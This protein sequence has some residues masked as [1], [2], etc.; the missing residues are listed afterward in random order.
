MRAGEK[1]AGRRRGAR[2]WVRIREGPREVGWKSLKLHVVLKKEI[3]ISEADGVSSSQRH[4]TQESPVEQEESCLGI[5]AMLS[6]CWRQPWE[7]C[8]GEQDGVFQE[9]YAPTT[10]IREVLSRG[11]YSCRGRP[12]EPA[13]GQSPLPGG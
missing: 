3:I 4:P 2:R 12:S 6:H 11:Y 10:E 8:S 1:E 5:P 13:L 9:N 7:L